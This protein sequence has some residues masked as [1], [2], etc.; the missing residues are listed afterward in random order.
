MTVRATCEKDSEVG[1]GCV[2]TSRSAKLP[3][4]G[5]GVKDANT[6][7][8]RMQVRSSGSVAEREML[9]LS[10]VGQTPHLHGLCPLRICQIIFLQA[11]DAPHF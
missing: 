1:R 8:V 2:G 3:L 6:L 11:M 5:N 9:M 10:Y 7:E 4:F